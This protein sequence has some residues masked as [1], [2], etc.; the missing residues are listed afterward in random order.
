MISMSGVDLFLEDLRRQC[1]QY[2][3]KLNF[4]RGKTVVVEG[5]I[6]SS[7]FFDSGGKELA[8]GK[9]RTDWLQLLVHESCHIDQ[10]IEDVKVWRDEDRLG[11]DI[12]DKWLLGKDFNK[13]KVKRA[14]NN[15]IR[16]EFDC[17]MRAI[18]KINEYDLPINI[19]SYIQRSNAYLYYHHRA[20]KNRTWKPA[21][22]ESFQIV[23]A[24]PTKMLKIDSYLHIP[25]KLEKYFIVGGF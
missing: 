9:N 1:K 18:Q 16:L 10:W 15:I 22:Y 14:V 17:E 6:R 19:A 8:I 12:F 11:N 13:T 21:V 7:G 3:V 23:N 25:K 2:K 5:N 4:R 20:L 24:M